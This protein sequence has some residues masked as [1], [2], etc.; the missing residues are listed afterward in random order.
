M[1]NEK[2]I[3]NLREAL[4]FI[5][6]PFAKMISDE[7]VDTIGQNIQRSIWLNDT[8]KYIWSVQVCFDNNIDWNS[9]ETEPKTPFCTYKAMFKKC[10]SLILENNP[11]I[12][13]IKI[14]R[15]N[16]NADLIE[17]IFT[18][19][20]ADNISEQIRYEEIRKYKIFEEAL[21]RANKH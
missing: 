9:I 12:K 3:A 4:G 2:Q 6:G 11:F 21:S 19:E 16:D 15:R 7:T 8:T 13:A 5:F 1:R 17:E 10:Y 20:W 14:S 18:L